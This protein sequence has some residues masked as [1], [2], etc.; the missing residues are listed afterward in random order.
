MTRI[1]RVIQ[2]RL[3]MLAARTKR[4]KDIQYLKD[5]VTE[6][7]DGMREAFDA[8]PRQQAAAEREARRKRLGLK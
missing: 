5:V 2:P 8:I 6:A 3:L 4:E 7:R 1:H